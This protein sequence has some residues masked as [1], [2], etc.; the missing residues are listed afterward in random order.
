[1]MWSGYKEQWVQKN[2]VP[3]FLIKN[4]DT[5]LG[6]TKM[7]EILEYVDMQINHILYENHEMA[8]IDFFNIENNK[9]TKFF[10]I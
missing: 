6:S 3:K 5:Y 10:F 9:I 7:T 1:M 4:E 2:K 8:D